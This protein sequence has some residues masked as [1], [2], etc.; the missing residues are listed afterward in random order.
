MNYVYIIL[1]YLKIKKL[2]LKLKKYKFYKQEVNFLGFRIKKL[3]IRIN[4]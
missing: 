1:K 4:L 3:K 2:L